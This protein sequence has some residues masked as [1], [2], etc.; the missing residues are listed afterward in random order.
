MYLCDKTL[1]ITPDIA[2]VDPVYL[3]HALNSSEARQHLTS[4]ATGTS[5]SMY[6]VS[7]GKIRSTPL[8]IPPLDRQRELAAV[9]EAA[10]ACV[11][12]LEAERASVAFL[13]SRLL[14]G[15]VSREIDIPE[16]YDVLLDAG[17]A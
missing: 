5:K 12:G 7:Q 13:R 9:L 8:R 15:L 6:N 1:R 3:V 4:S 16:A 17:V 2:V 14:Q 11:R 10:A